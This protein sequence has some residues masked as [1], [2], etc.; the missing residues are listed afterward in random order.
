MSCTASHQSER[1]MECLDTHRKL[2]FGLGLL[3]PALRLLLVVV[4]ASSYVRISTTRWGLIA[5]TL[6]LLLVVLNGRSQKYPLVFSVVLVL[7]VFWVFVGNLFFSP[8]E[9]GGSTWLIFRVNELGLGRGVVGV[10]IRGSMVLTGFAVISCSHYPDYYEALSFYV[11]RQASRKWILYFFRLFQLMGHEIVRC[12]QSLSVR[13]VNPHGLDVLGRMRLLALLAESLTVRL[14]SDVGRVAYTGETKWRAAHPRRPATEAEANLD[15]SDL[16][17]TYAQGPDGFLLEVPS[18]HLKA[19]EFVFLGGNNNS[20]KTTFLRAVA[21]YIPEF[22]GSREGRIDIGGSLVSS[23]PLADLSAIVQYLSEDPG[24]AIMGLTVC[25]DIMLSSGTEA[26][27]RE[28]LRAMGIEDLWG[29]QTPT[30]SG[31]QTARLALAGVLASGAKLL[32][33]DE[34]LQQLD[35]AGRQDFVEALLQYRK[36]TNTI[37][38]VT[39]HFL[40]EFAPYVTRFL[41]LRNGRVVVDQ[42]APFSC[43]LDRLF[44]GPTTESSGTTSSARRGEKPIA[45]LHGVHVE[46]EG[47]VILD[48]LDL[49]VWPGEVLA[50]TG[51]N[52]CG[53]S[54]AMLTLAGIPGTLRRQSGEVFGP[55]RGRVRYVFQDAPFQLVSR[56]V[57]DELCLR[58][59]GIDADPVET[60]AYA[61]KWL[62][63]LGKG[64]SEEIPDLSG[65]DARMLAFASM[66]WNVEMVVFDEPSLGL[67]HTQVGKLIQV[68]NELA[69]NGAAVV[70][71]SHDVRIIRAASR[72]IVMDR[73]KVVHDGESLVREVAR[74]PV[75]TKFGEFVLAGYEYGPE[76]RM[77][78][79]IWTGGNTGLASWPVRVQMGCVSGTALRSLDCD[80]W[81]Q[82]GAALEFFKRNGRG[83]LIY[84]PSE[85]GS[86]LGLSAKIQRMAR[87]KQGGVG[88]VETETR[89]GWPHANY[90]SLVYVPFILEGVGAREPIS[91]VTNSPQKCAAL[92]GM[93]LQIKDMI[94]LVVAEETLS[95]EARQELQEKRQRLGHLGPSLGEGHRLV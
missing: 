94:P 60:D 40:Y 15:I 6:S 77:A 43:D 22:T 85:E 21:G 75:T 5:F 55:G 68:L 84:F 12:R 74:F 24:E 53:K 69:E 19:G 62:S 88:P 3:P 65:P 44:A 20:G 42:M 93:G 18:L 48:G 87:E 25:Q 4:L 71:V 38:I 59:H 14:F 27:A 28:C 41:L 34:P 52:G 7:G 10:L 58:P 76:N 37:I 56:L 26:H 2:G 35:W 30:L 73:G 50:L 63:W 17:A 51:K 61:S 9:G 86:G 33:L 57:R 32:L 72:V 80:C 11:R 13:G 90:E 78:L 91:L 67:D 82:I 31:G 36:Q 92:S 45:G 23:L 49:E 46:H 81:L 39:D 1:D 64:G 29:H 95:K 8:P 79:V 66:T 89:E 47:Q 70:V 16:K 54:T 83:V